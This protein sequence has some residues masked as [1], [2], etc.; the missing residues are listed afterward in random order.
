MRRLLVVFVFLSHL[1]FSQTYSLN[2]VGLGFNSI[3]YLKH[4]FYEIGFNTKYHL[5]AWTFYSPSYQNTK[6]QYS[7]K[8]DSGYSMSRQNKKGETLQ[9]RYHF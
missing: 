4:T 6:P 1:A 3:N 9:E 5:P 7:N 8:E 2:K